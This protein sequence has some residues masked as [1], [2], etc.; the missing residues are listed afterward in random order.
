MDGDKVIAVNEIVTVAVDVIFGHVCL[1]RLF[2]TCFVE[3]TRLVVTARSTGIGPVAL[4][5]QVWTTELIED[6]LDVL[7][8]VTVCVTDTL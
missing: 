2:G 8:A 6:T 1:N 3:G 7:V 5:D 4:R